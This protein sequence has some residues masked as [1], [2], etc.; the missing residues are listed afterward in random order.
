VFRRITIRE[1]ERIAAISHMHTLQPHA[2]R[3]HVCQQVDDS[4]NPLKFNQVFHIIQEGNDF[5]CHND[6]FNL[7][8]G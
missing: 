4:P 5:W 2:H 8:Y 7:N 1:H 3:S 6:I